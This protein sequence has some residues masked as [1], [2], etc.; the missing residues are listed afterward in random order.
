MFTAPLSHC[1]ISV[2]DTLTERCVPI[3]VVYAQTSFTNVMCAPLPYMQ[4]YKK[5]A[6]M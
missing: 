2:F 3:Y 5:V 1:G 4:T 6:H